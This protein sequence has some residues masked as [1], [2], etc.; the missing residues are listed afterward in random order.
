MSRTANTTDAPELDASDRRALRTARRR[1]RL[2]T[3]LH[4]FALRLSRGRVDPDIA[5]LTTTGRRTGKQRTVPV[6][7]V[8]NNDRILIVAMNNGFDPQPAWFHNLNTD[9]DAV[10]SVRGV[11]TRVRARVVPDA[12]RSELWPELTRQRPLWAAFQAHTD[13]VAPVIELK[14]T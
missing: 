3:R 9:P 13:R 12:E 14:P 4:R 7:H 1:P 8:R 5:L 10:I 11:T 6:M 2:G